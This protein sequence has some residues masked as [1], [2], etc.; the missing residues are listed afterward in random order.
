M[1]MPRFNTSPNDPPEPPS[2]LGDAG[3]A[4]WIG[5]TT[6]YSFR[7][8]DEIPV[9]AQW[10]AVGDLIDRLAAE[11]A[12]QDLIVRG[13]MG[14]PATNPLVA[15]LHSARGQ[16]AALAK[17]LR[18][19][20][21]VDVGSGEVVA[22]RTEDLSSHASRARRGGQTRWAKEAAR[23]AEMAAQAEREAEGE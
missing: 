5:M 22:R 9:L 2:T 4:L 17:Q 13:S 16:Y 18:V 21:A 10:C 1:T 7:V 12:D 14:Q 23:R 3:R 11:L 8:A 20:D 15:S 19:P 6:R